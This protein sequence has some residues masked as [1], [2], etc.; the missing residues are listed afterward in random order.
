MRGLARNVSM[1][2]AA[3]T[4]FILAPGCATAPKHGHQL[5]DAN[6]RMTP[7]DAQALVYCVLNDPRHEHSLEPYEPLSPAFYGFG[8]L[9]RRA[10]VNPI[11]GG[12]MVNPW[13]GEVWDTS[14]PCKSVDTPDLKK[15]QVTIRNKLKLGNAAL[16]AASALKPFCYQGP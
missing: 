15:L 2:A 7:E 9:V 11:V 10:G 12:Y 14:D 4:L 8:V 1:L 3:M 5:L 13:S 6:R 16:A